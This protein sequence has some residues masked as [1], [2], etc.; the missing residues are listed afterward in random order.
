[1][2]TR[3][4]RGEG[5]VSKFKQK[6]KDGTVVT[7]WRA[8]AI[9]N[10]GPVG[11]EKRR[12]VYAD[13]KEAVLKKLESLRAAD[14]EG[15]DFDADRI[16]F[17]DYA[18]RWLCDVIKPNRSNN[19]HRQ[20]ESVLTTHLIP[21]FGDVRLR[22]LKAPMIREMLAEMERAGKSNR[23]RQVART[24]LSAIFRQAVADA[25]LSRNPCASVAAVRIPRGEMS[26][27]TPAQVNSLLQAANG[28]RFEAL[29]HVGLMTGARQG[30]IFA[31]RWSDVDLE[32]GILTVQRSLEEIS[33]RIEFK[34]TK[35]DK[36]RR[37]NLAPSTIAALRAHRAATSSKVVALRSNHRDENLVFFTRNRAGERV[38]LRKSN[39]LRYEYRP[40]L[41]AAG[42]VE[43]FHFHGLRHTC[44]SLLL[45]NGESVNVVAEQLG[46]DPAMTLRVYAHVL[47]GAQS[48][49]VNRLEGMLRRAKGE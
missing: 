25:Y 3:R 7:R 39:F 46:H 16:R 47:P 26:T 48:E 17:G 41:K 13:T 31:L 10:R 38:P 15:V 12:T 8:S 4:G 36:V 24:L 32:G 40:L 49:A 27:L 28:N 19:T 22:D 20:Y 43:S 5:S 9:V 29:Y 14:R 6:L 42:I 2:R 33:G 21:R 35:A 30:E 23:L 1:M 11:Y 45:A 18:T 37:V 44:A 34:S